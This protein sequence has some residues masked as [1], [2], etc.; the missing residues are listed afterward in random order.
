M[1]VGELTIKKEFLSR[2][3]GPDPCRAY[4]ADRGGQ[5]RSAGERQVQTSGAS[6]FGCLLPKEACG[7]E[8]RSRPHAQDRRDPS[9]ASVPRHIQC[10]MRLMGLEA[11]YPKRKASLLDKAHTIYSHPRRGLAITKSNHVRWVDLTYIHMQ[12]GICYL[13]ATV[14]WA[15]SAVLSWRLSLTL[16][17]EACVE[18][19]GEAIAHHGAPEIF[20][21]AK[22]RALPL[23]ASL[24]SRG[25]MTLTSAWTAK[26]A[27][28]SAQPAPG[29]QRLCR[30][31]ALPQ[32]QI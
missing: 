1:K 3:L 21:S 2:V 10:L 9:P 6:A 31:T 32:W 19:L 13:V 16:E 29:A 14:G 7:L 5:P 20:N 18:T 28:A 15:T 4:A 12:R 17:P 22:G 27:G 30:P 26:A 23:M 8:R 24:V 25:P 11:V